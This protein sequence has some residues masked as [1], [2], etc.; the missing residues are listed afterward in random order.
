M[1]AKRKD[2]YTV[3]EICDLWE[4]TEDDIWYYVERKHLTLSLFLTNRKAWVYMDKALAVGACNLT[5]VLSIP[6]SILGAILNESSFKCPWV[7]PC[8]AG[9]GYTT[10]QWTQDQPVSFQ[11]L[12]Q[13]QHS[14]TPIAEEKFTDEKRKRAILYLPP[15]EVWWWPALEKWMP[16]VSI[17][18]RERREL[19]E[20]HDQIPPSYLGDNHTFTKSDLRITDFHRVLADSALEPLL[21]LESSLRSSGPC[22][23]S[24]LRLAGHPFQLFQQL[25]ALP[26]SGEAHPV[27]DP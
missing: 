1:K 9:L 4:C 22:L 26:V 3:P 24:N 16:A 19:M 11:R 5:G 14:W 2:Y 18:D 13:G 23:A 10:K 17:T 25:R 15:D 6:N 27:D 8:H 12:F 21:R 20:I 7:Y